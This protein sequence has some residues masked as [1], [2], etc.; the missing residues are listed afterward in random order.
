MV[1]IG[2]VR[3]TV[4]GGPEDSRELGLMKGIII[5]IRSGEK[6]EESQN[7]LIAMLEKLFSQMSIEEKKRILTEEYGMIM[8]AEL[9]GRIQLMCNWSEVMIEKGIEK[10]ADQQLAK[11][12]KI[13]RDK[14]KSVEQIAEEL[15]ET[16]ARIQEVMEKMDLNILMLSAEKE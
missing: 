10:G 9:E 7:R 2:L 5:R 13:K 1:E 16:E 6:L 14:G 15:E 8:T 3:K 12:I 11:Q 4:F